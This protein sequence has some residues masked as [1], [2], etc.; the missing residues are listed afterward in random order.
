MNAIEKRN[1]T[2]RLEKPALQKLEK[3]AKRRGLS[4]SE[5]I[6]EIIRDFLKEEGEL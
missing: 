4:K 6:R 5:L 3:I 1:V 2:F